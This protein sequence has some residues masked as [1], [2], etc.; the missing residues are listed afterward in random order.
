MKV[1]DVFVQS[2]RH[3]ASDASGINDFLDPGEE[4]RVAQDMADHHM[5]FLLFGAVQD[6]HAL[7]GIRGNGLFQQDVVAQFQCFHHLRVMIPIHR[8]N[9]RRVGDF[10]LRPQLFRRSEAPIR[11]HAQLGRSFFAAHVIRLYDGHDLRATLFHHIIRVHPSALSCADQND[12][13]STF[14]LTCDW[15]PCFVS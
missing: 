14:L 13:H 3:K 7:G 5:Q 8:G 1:S 2:N 12:F 6:V 9:D 10:S 15:G 11:S 4:R